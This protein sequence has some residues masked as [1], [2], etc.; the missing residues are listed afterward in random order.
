[1]ARKRFALRNK[2]LK[3]QMRGCAHFQA[4]YTQGALNNS[5]AAYDAY[6][7]MITNTYDAIHDRDA[8]E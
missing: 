4:E 1:M 3:M 2:P 7:R 8:D 5:V 6:Q